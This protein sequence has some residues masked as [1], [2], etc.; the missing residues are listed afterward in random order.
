MPTITAGG[1][2]RSYII[3][4]DDGRVLVVN[5]TSLS[6]MDSVDG[7]ANNVIDVVGLLANTN[8]TNG[9]AEFISASGQGFAVETG[10]AKDSYIISF[11]DGRVLVIDSTEL[12]SLV[13]LDGTSGTTINV[14]GLLAN[15]N[16]SGERIALPT[17]V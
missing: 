12:N 15:S 10:P 2:L 7:S 8:P 9:S 6:T 16:P 4:F 17:W 13:S 3:T 5:D 1:E 11:D 14:D